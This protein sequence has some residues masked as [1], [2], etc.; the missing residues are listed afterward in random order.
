MTPIKLSGDGNMAVPS[1]AVGGAKQSET[2]REVWVGGKQEKAGGYRRKEGSEIGRKAGNL[3][4]RM[5]VGR[6]HFPYLLAD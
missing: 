4:A 1:V 2:K 5:M 3:V 6:V